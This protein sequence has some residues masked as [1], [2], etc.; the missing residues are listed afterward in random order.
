[1]PASVTLA[2]N[3]PLPR[4]QTDYS[5]NQ[6]KLEPPLPGRGPHPAGVKS[7]GANLTPLSGAARYG[8][9]GTEGLK[10]RSR[11]LLGVPWSDATRC[12]T[13]GRIR[14]PPPPTLRTNPKAYRRCRAYPD[15]P[16][17][18]NF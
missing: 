16:T 14:G 10:V 15:S 11:N 7:A 13:L 12:S 2:W 3:E 5:C 4:D 18:Q 17:C 9:A 6:A 1:M 8:L